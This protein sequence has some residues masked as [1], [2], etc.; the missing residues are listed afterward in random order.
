VSNIIIAT[1]RLSDNSILTVDSEKLNFEVANLQTFQPSK[2]WRDESGVSTLVSDLGS[3]KAINVISLLYSNASSVATWRIRI[4]NTLLGLTSSPT[5]DSGVISFW[6]SA[7]LEFW[8][9]I[10]GYHILDTVVNGQFVQID[11][12]DPTNSKGYFQAGRICIDAAWQPTKNIS[13]QWQISVKD[14]ST[15]KMTHGG[16]I[17]VNSLGKRRVLEFTL[18]FLNEDEMFDYAFALD[19]ERGQSKPVLVIPNPANMDRIHDQAV[20]GVMTE[21][22]P[23]INTRYSIFEKRYSVEEAI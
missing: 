3:I 20:Y 9:R 22:S 13:Y 14:D 17:V 23:I 16:N 11:L 10:S 5:Y 7:S 6:P 1:P 21:L 18:G 15:N 19:R 4:A 12:S 2:V 8:D